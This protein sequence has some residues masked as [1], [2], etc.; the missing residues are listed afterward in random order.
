MGSCLPYPQLVADR[1]SAEINRLV[2]GAG[3]TGHSTGDSV[4]D[5]CS[6]TVAKPTVCLYLPRVALVCLEPPSLPPLPLLSSRTLPEYIYVDL[7]LLTVFTVEQSRAEQR[8]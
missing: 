1:V 6:A 2:A 7:L 8:R 4:A 5:I 3:G